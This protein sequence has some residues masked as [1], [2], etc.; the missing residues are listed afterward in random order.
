MSKTDICIWIT[1]PVGAMLVFNYN[2]SYVHKNPDVFEI[3][4]FFLHQSTFRPHETSESAHR[5]HF[6][7]RPLS[8]VVGPVHTNTGKKICGVRND[9]IRVDGAQDVNGIHVD[10]TGKSHLL[11]VWCVFKNSKRGCNITF[12]RQIPSFA[13][14]SK[15]FF[16]SFIYIAILKYTCT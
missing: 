13:N 3:A 16:F 8:T 10:S 9:W 12:P 6:F 15:C 7:L 5:N 1:K 2:L 4:Y 14:Q 11:G